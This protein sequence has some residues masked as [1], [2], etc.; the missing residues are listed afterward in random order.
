[1]KYQFIGSLHTH[2]VETISCSSEATPTAHEASIRPNG[3]FAV[4][5][6]VA[7]MSTQRTLVNV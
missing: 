7:H 1:M 2:A 5:S 4:L 6:V 3:V